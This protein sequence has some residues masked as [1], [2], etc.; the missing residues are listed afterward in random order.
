MNDLAPIRRALLSVS[1][2][3]GLVP[4]AQ[5]LAERGITILSTGGTARTL[6]DAGIAVTDVSARHWLSRRSWMGG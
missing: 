4:F 1:D 3:Q 6:K 5:G 2:K